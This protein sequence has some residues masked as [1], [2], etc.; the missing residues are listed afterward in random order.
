MGNIVWIDDEMSNLVTQSLVKKGIQFIQFSI[1]GV[2]NT[3]ISYFIYAFCIY[4][5]LHYVIANVIAF[6]ISV[7]NSYYWNNRYVFKD[8]GD[9]RTWWKTLFKTY[10]SY[11]FTGLVLTNILSFLWIDIV[12]ISAYLAP[13]A[14]LFICTPINYLMNKYWAYKPQKKEGENEQ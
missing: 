11:A 10:L 5:G 12:G 6:L 8:E 4:I 14:N 3:I 7:L 9:S 1:V 2:S 13:I